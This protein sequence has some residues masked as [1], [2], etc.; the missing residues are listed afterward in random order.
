[1]DIYLAIAF[2]IGGPILVY[3]L[4]TRKQKYVPPASPF[5][6]TYREILLRDV[7]FYERLDAAGRAAFEERMMRFLARTRITG[8]NTTVEEIDKVYI[9]A[10]AIIPIFGFKDWEYNNLNEVLLYPESFSHDFGQT[11]SGRNLL[12]IVGE[13]PLQRVMVLSRHE[14]RQAFRNKA[15]KENT[16][17]HEFVH[18][19]DKSDGSVDGVPEF[20]VDRAYVRPWVQLIHKEIRNILGNRSDIDPYG[21]TN[22]AEFFAVVSEYFFE[23][24]DLLEQNHPELYRL[25]TELFKTKPVS[26][27]H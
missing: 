23:R 13:G 2:I 25:L 10:S 4:I 24:P 22:E 16:A 15:S 7:P 17:I 26:S 14:L 19:I 21:A 9:A 3:V 18:L 6:G 8:V 12:G 11:G 5:P 27:P 1:M 20:F